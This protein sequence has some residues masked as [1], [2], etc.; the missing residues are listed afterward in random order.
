MQN[1]PLPN[2]VKW[3]R[4]DVKYHRNRI[5]SNLKPNQIHILFVHIRIALPCAQ[6]AWMVFSAWGVINYMANVF[7]RTHISQFETKTQFPNA[8]NQMNALATSNF[9]IF[10]RVIIMIIVFLIFDIVQN[11]KIYT[12]EWFFGLFDGAQWMRINH[13]V[14]DISLNTA[15]TYIVI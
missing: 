14:Y 4:L 7:C 1:K 8:F 6:F 2:E 3:T 13:I 12:M 15:H 10:H 9:H 11:V 5:E